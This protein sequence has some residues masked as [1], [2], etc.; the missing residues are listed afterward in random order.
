MTR[1]GR[2]AVLAS[3]IALA[4]PASQARAQAG[5]EWTKDLG[6]ALD[7]AR[8]EGK[9]VLIDF[10]AT[11]CGPCREMEAQLW[12][13]PDV[14]ALSKKFVFVKVDFDN[15]GGLAQRYR[16]ESIPALVIMDPW[17]T[18]IAR[19]E[20]F[21]EPSPYLSLLNGMPSDFAPLGPWQARLAKDRNDLEALREIGRLYYRMNLFHTS[22][23][24]LER[25]LKTKEARNQPDVLA[26]IQT[27][28]GWDYLKA[29]D[30]RAARKAFEACLADSPGH[31]GAQVTLYGLLTACRLSGQRPEAEAALARLESCCPGSPVVERARVE[32]GLIAKAAD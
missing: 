16:I 11:W 29:G 6:R 15:A 9:P 25:A 30:T 10:W 31:P 17:G 7:R 20:G 2:T 23:E 22:R 4:L 13:R 14:T 28:I 19:R 24:F 12:A 26:D 21:G 18:E 27:A 32:L 8:T 3:C 5:I 1:F